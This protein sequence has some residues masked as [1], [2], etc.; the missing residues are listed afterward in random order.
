MVGASWRLAR[1]MLGEV[2]AKMGPR[3]T[4][5]AQDGSTIGKNA[6]DGDLGPGAQLGSIS[7][8][9]TRPEAPGLKRMAGSGSGRRRRRGWGR[10]RV[11]KSPP[12]LDFGI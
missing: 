8:F 2:G 4:K 12:G 1:T 7:F 5:I 11:G 3:S 9:K 10:V 6:S